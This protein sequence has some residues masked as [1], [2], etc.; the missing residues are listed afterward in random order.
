MTYK[1]LFGPVPSRRLG[2]SLGIDLVPY[3]TCTLDCVYCECG[4]T[5]LLTTERREYVPTGE[6]LDEL[7][8][9]LKQKP[10]LDYITF[11]GSGEPTLHTGL[12][13]IIDFIKGKYPQYKVAV[14]TNGTLLWDKRVREGILGADLISPSLDAAGEKAF[15][16]VNRPHK[17][18]SLERIISGLERLREEFKGEIWLE[19]FMV[20]GLNDDPSELERIKAAIDRIKPDRVQLNTLDRPGTE[21]WVMPEKKS[22][23]EG[24]AA[25]LGGEVIAKFRSRKKVKSF[26]RDIEEEILSTLGRRPCTAKDLSETMGMHINEVNKYLQTLLES[27]RICGERGERGTF[28]RIR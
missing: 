3:K 12:K 28:F 6:I 7:D 5:T 15:R 1:H 2:V 18:L 23:L 21:D 16:A 20:P 26:S 19:V 4:K 14:L 10:E 9:Y 24:I 8:D 17:D 25:Y 11:S 22:E 27:G 13:A